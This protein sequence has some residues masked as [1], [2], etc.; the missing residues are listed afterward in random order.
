MSGHSKWATTKRQKAVVDAKKGAIFTK[1]AKLITIVARKGNDPTTNFSLRIAIDKAKSINMPKD[2]IDRAI[3]HGTGESDGTQI[4]ELTY[5]GLG[6]A[7]TQF[8]VKCLSRNKNRTAAEIRHLFSKYGGSLSMVMWNF[9]Q[10]GIIMIERE[11][12]NNK[13][14]TNE[15]FELELIDAGAEDIQT[16]DQGLTIYTAPRDLQKTKQFL[17]NKN[18]KTESA[19][20]EYIA[21]ES[22]NL[23]GEEKIRVEKFIEELDNNEDVSNYYTNANL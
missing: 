9:A 3:K 6:P 1:I 14:L 4:E 20:I 16:E 5:E 7:K 13:K 15:N 21:K 22:I 2:N 8:I 12:I 19:E 10:H 23:S 18:I 17:E 11:E